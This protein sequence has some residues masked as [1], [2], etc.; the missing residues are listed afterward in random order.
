M[1]EPSVFVHIPRGHVVGSAHS[2]MSGTKQHRILA[3]HWRK[4]KRNLFRQQKH[5]IHHD[6]SSRVLIL[7]MKLR[8]DPLKMSFE[9]PTFAEL[10]VI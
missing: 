2:S 4:K 5:L 3:I 7:H 1:K 6:R 8:M 9:L 10:A